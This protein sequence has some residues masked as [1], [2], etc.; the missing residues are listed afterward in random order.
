MC[1]LIAFSGASNSGK[2]TTIRRIIERYP[3]S[4]VVLD[5]I[6]RRREGV[7]IDNIRSN[8]EE[9]LRFQREVNFKKIQ[10]EIDIY[11]KYQDT[12]IIV[13]IDRSIVD[14]LFY[15]AFYLDKSSLSESDLLS[16][17]DMFVK[18]TDYIKQSV[19][20]RVLLFEPIPIIQFDN[21]IR[22]KNLYIFQE[23][24]Y[25]FIKHLSYACFGNNRVIDIKTKDI[26][27]LIDTIVNL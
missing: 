14:S 24:E 6:I 8:P 16:Y 4:C 25:F 9:Y 17:K 2:T 12:E 1:K 11:R 20:Y 5:E 23:F 22:T 26:D 13:L 15:C 7:N 3:Q 27:K 10:E 21:G 19:Y 18:M